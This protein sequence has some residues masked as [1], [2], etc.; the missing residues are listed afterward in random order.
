[1]DIQTLRCL[2]CKTDFSLQAPEEEFYIKFPGPAQTPL[3]TPK[4][5][6]SCRFQRRLC[7]RHETKLYKRNCD[8]SAKPIIS[9]YSLDKP[10]KV[11]AADVYWSDAWN[12]LSYGIPYKSGVSFFE[13]F[14]AQQ[15]IV[16]RINLLTD[17]RNENSEYV[18]QAN[19]VRNCY[20]VCGSV[21]A[22]DCYYSYRIFNSRDSLD[23]AFV[24]N[25]ELCYECFDCADC[26]SSSYLFKSTNCRNSAFL[27]DCHACADCLF[28]SNLKNKQYYIFNQSYS[29]EQFENF[30]NELALYSV[31]GMQSAREQFERFKSQIKYC[32]NYNLNSENS[33]GDDLT[34]C[35]NSWECYNCRELEDC[36]Y[37]FLMANAKDC[38]DT[39]YA[40]DDD[41]LCYECC[42]VGENSYA[43]L[44]CIDSWNIQNC[45]YCDTCLNCKNCFG[46]I[47]LMNQEFCI[48]NRQYTAAEYKELLPKIVADMQQRGEYGEFFPAAHSSLA[49]NETPAQIYFP[50][51]K[52][53]ALQR[54]LNWKDSEPKMG[55]K[56]RFRVPSQIS[57]AG[58]DLLSKTLCCES[59]QRGYK[60]IKP[61]L[62]LHQR[63]NLALPVICASC[64]LEQRLKNRSGRKLKAGLCSC[65]N[66][67]LESTYLDIAGDK[68]YCEACYFKQIYD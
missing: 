25:C 61:E 32:E 29:K 27:F 46:C 4:L 24:D 34:N 44:A 30:R 68:L 28:S 36:R 48:L 58:N 15:L 37:C 5:C 54:G 63:L 16:P 42:T 43:A 39:C 38:Q 23:C 53:I 9:A 59:C 57:K 66:K 10:Y 47:G 6:P 18:N 8:L 52:E 2:Q 14:K 3:S 51:S 40:W 12:P 41:E 31:E 26:Y 49:Y 50:L 64:R 56:D 13:Q 7:F 60:L 33:R 65:C 20:L 17:P 11:Y 45:A 55:V 19:R 35:K 22:E 21:N 62:E 1:M 67:N